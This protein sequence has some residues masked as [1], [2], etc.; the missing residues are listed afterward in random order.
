[1]FFNKSLIIWFFEHMLC[2]TDDINHTYIYINRSTCTTV[3]PVQL[4][5]ITTSHIVIYIISW[6]GSTLLDCALLSLWKMA[7]HLESHNEILLLWLSLSCPWLPLE[8]NEM[9]E[10]SSLKRQRDWSKVVQRYYLKKPNQFSYGSQFRHGWIWVGMF[11]DPQV[12]PMPLQK[13]VRRRWYK[14]I[15][16]KVLFKSLLDGAR[17]RFRHLAKQIAK[18]GEE[19]LCGSIG[20]KPKHPSYIL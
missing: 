6:F 1:M 16:N 18:G 14:D 3:Q 20:M 10:T 5:T 4:H 17:F 11:G 9:L 13:I 12:V 15:V 2:I 8:S 7:S 19:S